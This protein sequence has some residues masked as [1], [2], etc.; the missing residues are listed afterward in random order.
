M[1][2]IL[3]PLTFDDLPTKPPLT[4]RPKITEDIQQTAALLVG[5]DKVTRRLVFVNPQGVLHSISPPVDGIINKQF[6]SG[7][8]N[9]QPVDIKTSEVLIRAKPT[10]TGRIWVNV[11]AAAADNTGYPL[12]SGE[13]VT[14][15]VNNLRDLQFFSDTDDDW[16]IIVYTK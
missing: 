14:L 7:T 10:N 6:P 16:I 9:Y 1:R 2:E 8:D 4:G 13:P 11:G 3:K 12:D 15:S 5:F